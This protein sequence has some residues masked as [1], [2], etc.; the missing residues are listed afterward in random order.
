MRE[1]A[2][3]GC[4]HADVIGEELSSLRRGNGN[5]SLPATR[6]TLYLACDTQEKTLEWARCV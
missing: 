1:A 5:V 4:D 6:K 3:G 2:W